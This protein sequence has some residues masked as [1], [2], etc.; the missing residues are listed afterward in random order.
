MSILSLQFHRYLV[1]PFDPQPMH[2]IA[3]ILVFGPMP[4]DRAQ[5]PPRLV[6]LAT[7]RVINAHDLWHELQNYWPSQ[8]DPPYTVPEGWVWCWHEDNEVMVWEILG[9]HF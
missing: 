2:Q 4:M 6:G 8:Q 3:G 9:V 1:G 7:E 5:V